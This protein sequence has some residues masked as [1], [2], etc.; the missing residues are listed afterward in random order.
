MNSKGLSRNRRLVTLQW[1]TVGGRWLARVWAEAWAAL[2]HITDGG[3]VAAIP[4]RN[5]EIS[6]IEARAE[7]T[8]G[9]TGRPPAVFSGT[10]PG[11]A[12]C[13]TD[14]LGPGFVS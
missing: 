2:A 14:K 3:G 10:D 7:C 6:I 11:V 13:P 1:L 4:A 8:P 5:K 12:V 9:A